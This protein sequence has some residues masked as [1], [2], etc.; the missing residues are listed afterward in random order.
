MKIN[1]LRPSRTVEKKRALGRVLLCCRSTFRDG[2]R[3]GD[4][5]QRSYETAFPFRAWQDERGMGL[6][7]TILMMMMVSVVGAALL[8]SMSADLGASAN[9][10][11]LSTAFY[12]AESGVELTLVDFAADAA[13]L[14][15]VLDGADIKNPPL[16]TF[17]INGHTITISMD[18]NGDPIP[19]YYDLGSS[20]SIPTASYIREIYFPLPATELAQ[21]SNVWLTI[22]VRS[23]GSAGN[24][25]PSTQL[26]GVDV[27][28]LVDPPTGPWNYALAT[29][30]GWGNEAIDDS[31]GTLQI[32]GSVRVFGDPGDPPQVQ[33][34]GDAIVMNHY[35]GLDDGSR[36]GAFASKLPPLDTVEVNGETV[37]TLNA[38]M[39]IEDADF[40]FLDNGSWGETDVSGNNFKEQLDGVYIDGTLTFSG[41]GGAYGDDSGGFQEDNIDFPKLSDPYTSPTTGTSYGTHIA[42]LNAESVTLPIDKISQDTP[43]FD[44]SDVQGNRIAWDPGTATLEV[45]GIIKRPGDLLFEFKNNPG[46][47]ITYVGTGT[48]YATNLLNI[49]A[50]LVPAGQYIDDDN[51]GLIAGDTLYVGKKDIND[52]PRIMAAAYAG[53]KAVIDDGSHFAGALVAGYADFDASAGTIVHVPAVG[54]RPP[55]GMPGSGAGGYSIIQ[56]QTREWFQER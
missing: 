8:T 12:G 36:F 17:A 56:I 24:A 49:H 2:W 13:W 48:I 55:P 40:Q 31:Q 51:L 6:I 25:E 4:D 10:Q 16:S 42:F 34:K 47:T 23:T 32:R 20:G 30:D 21:G 54:L 50:D 11:S 46:T 1:S 53:N 22:P 7:I 26:V 14:S 3:D 5:Y 9:Y 44:Y 45:T 29:G 43:A 15:A 33:W 38:I 39:N 28:L 18:G 27:R 19:G 35:E 41:A 37:E 52:V